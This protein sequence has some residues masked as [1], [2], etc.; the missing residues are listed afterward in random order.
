MEGI[1]EEKK[2]GMKKGDIK[3]KKGQK[4]RK[5]TDGKRGKRKMEKVR[6]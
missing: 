4:E 2:E 1:K 5:K 3:R 6:N